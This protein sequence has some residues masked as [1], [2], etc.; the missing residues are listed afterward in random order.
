MRGGK[1]RDLSLQKETSHT[2]LNQI[3]IEFLFYNLKINILV[4]KNYKLIKK[5]DTKCIPTVSCC[6]EAYA[7]SKD[8]S[9][10]PTNTVSR[11]ERTCS[12]HMLV[13]L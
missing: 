3:K 8:N 5:F 4:W 12:S 1:A 11:A 7:E 10:T 9:V 6:T 13:G 2:Y